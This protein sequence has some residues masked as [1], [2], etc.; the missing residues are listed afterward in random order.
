MQNLHNSSI[1]TQK[2]NFEFL[3]SRKKWVKSI[4]IGNKGVVDGPT[5]LTKITQES[6]KE[7]HGNLGKSG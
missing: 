5:A 3:S 6:E 2:Q 7:R 4:A 1:M